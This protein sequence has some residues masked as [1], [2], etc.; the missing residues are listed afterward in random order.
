[1]CSHLAG[2]PLAARLLAPHFPSSLVS[3]PTAP[4]TR[5]TAVTRV[6]LLI[7]AIVC[8]LRLVT[9]K[10]R[11]DTTVTVNLCELILIWKDNNRFCVSSGLSCPTQNRHP[12][13]SYT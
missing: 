12:T 5:I 11:S 8:V 1:M 4:V 13:R 3:W 7:G 2:L 10:L 6:R 9:S